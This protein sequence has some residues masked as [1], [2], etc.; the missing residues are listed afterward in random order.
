MQ[1]AFCIIYGYCLIGSWNICGISAPMTA[2]MHPGS[3]EHLG[4]IIANENVPSLFAGLHP[5][6]VA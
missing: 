4:N 6:L 2:N 5:A 1:W 3:L